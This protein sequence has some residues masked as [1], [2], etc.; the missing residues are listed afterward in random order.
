[1]AHWDRRTKSEKG[2]YQPNIVVNRV[3]IDQTFNKVAK[4]LQS[5]KVLRKKE[6]YFIKNYIV[7]E[8]FPLPSQFV[9]GRDFSSIYVSSYHS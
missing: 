8:E 5:S 9:D 1:M 3:I 7:K 6:K 4:N 2:K